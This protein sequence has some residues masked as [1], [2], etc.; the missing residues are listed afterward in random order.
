MAQLNS[1]I[2]IYEMEYGVEVNPGV[3]SVM[4]TSLNQ[5]ELQ[6]IR[7]NVHQY[8]QSF[9]SFFFQVVLCILFAWIYKN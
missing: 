3:Y 1:Y 9:A 7:E 6:T 5:L 2:P 4:L 8:S